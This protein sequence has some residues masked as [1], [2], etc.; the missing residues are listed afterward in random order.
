MAYLMQAAGYRTAHVGKFLNRFEP[1]SIEDLPD[2]WDRF[3]ATVGSD[4][5]TEGSLGPYYDYTLV[6]QRGGGYLTEEH[7]D[8][9]AEHST[10]VLTDE[11]IGFIASEDR[12]PLFLQLAYPAPHGRAGLIPPVP[13]VRDRDAPVALPPL[14][15]AVNESSVEDKPSFI[16]RRGYIPV[17]VLQRWRR[18]TARTLFGVDRGI[19]RVL[20][21]QEQRD[22]GLANTLVVF[23]S[24]NGFAT[25]EHR[26]MSK[27]VPYE[28]AIKVPLR[29]HWNGLPP[30]RVET[31]VG[32]IDV[33][34]TIMDAAAVAM[35][36]PDSISLLD[37]TRRFL[38]LEGL[39]LGRAYCG[40]RTATRKFV[41]YATGE[42]EYYNL[43]RDPSELQNGSL[44]AAG[45]RMRMFARRH[46]AQ[47]LPPL[48]P[49]E[50]R[51]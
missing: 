38:V 40:V 20:T 39:G 42:R 14:S 11:A 46:C 37:P 18:Q 24:D 34:A 44:S 47:N 19:D 43:R 5:L 25:G 29:V 8:E 22:P 26:W 9:P 51:Y 31:L 6:G 17:R 12:R 21:A 48:W 50:L 2:G 45:E 36:A 32:N 7:G 49:E 28:G 30:G 35:D 33:A 3:I 27:G 41:M 1:R 4:E 16:Q 23:M 13:Q 10:R 15:R